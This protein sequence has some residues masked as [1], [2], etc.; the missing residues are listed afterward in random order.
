MTEMSTPGRIDKV[1]KIVA[2]SSESWEVA[3]QNAVTEAAR[4]I[5]DLT[6]ARVLERDLTVASGTP[7]YRIKLEVAFQI[8][9]TRWDEAGMPMQVRRYLI[10]ANQTLANAEL[11]DLVRAHNAEFRAEFHVV[12]PQSA[13]SVLHADPST[14]LIGPAAHDIVIESRAV[15]REEGERRLDSFRAALAD[16]GGDVTGEVVLVDPVAAARTV[17]SRASFDEIIISTLPAGI[18]RWLKL[19]LPSRVER[20][21][22]L[23]VTT[24]VQRE[25]P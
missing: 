3:A 6:S 5:R 8:D 2:A 24:L 13:P 23:P 11:T 20:A 9:R 22:S 16:L 14:G 19:D 12:V 10:L 15:A 4:S 21:F 1:V 17:M 18:S 25:S 7:M